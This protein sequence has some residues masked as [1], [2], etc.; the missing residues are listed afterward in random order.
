MNKSILSLLV[1]F[2]L[3]GCS[4]VRAPFVPSTAPISVV[5]APLDLEVKSTK[6]G[7]KQGSSSVFTILGLISVGNASYEAAA[8]FFIDV[9]QSAGISEHRE[10]QNRKTKKMRIFDNIF[11]AFSLNG[12]ARVDD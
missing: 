6:T 4:A 1:L 8:R 12:A 11:M 10:R 9:L 5:Q 2:G 7:L 3:S